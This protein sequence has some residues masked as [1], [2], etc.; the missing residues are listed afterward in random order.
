MLGHRHSVVTRH[1]AIDLPPG[2]TPCP[3]LTIAFAAD[4]HAGPAT[5]PSVLR[6]AGAA[7][8]AA[9]PDVL[10][11]GGDFVDF[12][13]DEIDTLLPHF[14]GIAAPFGRYAVLGNHD[15][16]AD[17]D[18]VHE[19]LESAGIQVLTNRNARLS[20]PYEHIWI[21]GLDDHWCGHP[22]ADAA[23]AGADGLRVVVMHAPSGILDVGQHRFDIAF[24]G[25]TH[26]GQIALSGGRPLVLPSG[27]LS[28]RYARGRFQL[29][30]G[31]HLIV[32]VGV[33]CVLLPLRIHA[34]PEVVVCTLARTA[35]ESPR[36]PNPERCGTR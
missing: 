33:G 11:L 35:G 26:G 27:A 7:L 18:R 23:F 16:L 13:P 5:D 32:T 8:R 1:Y 17:P 2:P 4:F 19:R 20:P 24:A 22:D 3:S 21:C 9:A 31:E 15:W 30:H 28:R 12:G 34:D 14:S 36:A 10:L 29:P 25:H 6:A